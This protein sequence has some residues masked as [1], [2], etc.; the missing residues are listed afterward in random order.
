MHNAFKSLWLLDVSIL[1][2]KTS[3]NSKFTIFVKDQYELDFPVSR[4]LLH[5]H[6]FNI[7]AKV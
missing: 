1:I 5:D 7:A 4:F 3:M 2:N 6:F